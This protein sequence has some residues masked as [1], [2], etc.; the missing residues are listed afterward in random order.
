MES[1]L[2]IARYNEDINWVNNLDTF[3]KKIIYNKGENLQNLK[4]SNHRSTKYREGITY[5]A[6]SH[7]SKL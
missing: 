7:C 4:Y 5:M 6:S 1:T 2:V 3:S